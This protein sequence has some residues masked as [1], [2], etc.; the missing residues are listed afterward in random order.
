[1]RRGWGMRFLAFVLAIL[2][3]FYAKTQRTYNIEILIPVEYK[4]LSRE[5]AFVE[6]PDSFVVAEITVK[7][8]GLLALV[9]LSPRLTVDLSRV[10]LGR[11]TITISP[12][13]L[14][15]RGLDIGVRGFRPQELDFILDTIARK[16]PAVVPEIKGEPEKGY[17]VS[18]LRATGSPIVEGPGVLIMQTREIHTEP[19]N[20]AG[21]CSGFKAMTKLIP[22][23]P[24]AKIQPQEIEVEVIIEPL[25][26]KSLAVPVVIE[27]KR[28]WLS[29]D[30]VVITIEGPASLLSAFSGTPGKI[31]ADTLSSGTYKLSPEIRLP[32][33]IRLVK[34][35]PDKVEV[36]VW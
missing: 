16:R 25:S 13:D 17:V 2:L 27:G 10:K 34:M 8:T 18:G 35:E 21:R 29:P 12:S 1:M 7:G 23:F 33:D 24:S 19:V 22:P 3:W 28:A 14:D 11:N 9:F 26:A 15:T 31:R 30:S 20:I 5:L 4:G 36:R 6:R 32:K